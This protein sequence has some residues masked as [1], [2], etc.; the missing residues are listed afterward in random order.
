[1]NT[2]IIKIIIEALQKIVESLE[3][4]Q[5]KGDPFKTRET[6]KGLRREKPI[7]KPGQNGS[8]SDRRLDLMIAAFDRL[9]VSDR[10][11]MDFIGKP[12]QDFNESDMNDL[13]AIHNRLKKGELAEDVFS[14]F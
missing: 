3:G 2:E 6:S 14:P 7:I 10:T 9:N 13:I 11:L 8:V 5:T 12:L 1:M 4:P